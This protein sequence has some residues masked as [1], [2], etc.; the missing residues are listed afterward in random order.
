ME[1]RGSARIDTL[2]ESG[3]KVSSCIGPGRYILRDVENGVCELWAGGKSPPAHY[4]IK[5]GP[6]FLEFVS[7]DIFKVR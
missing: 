6:W 2:Q 4:C 3:Y 7:S 1:E 5:Y